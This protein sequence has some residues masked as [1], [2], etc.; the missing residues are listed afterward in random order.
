[1]IGRSA[2]AAASRIVG[3]ARLI[4]SAGARVNDLDACSLNT[5]DVVWLFRGI[6]LWQRAAWGVKWRDIETASYYTGF[7]S[8]ILR[9]YTVRVGHRFTRT[10]EIVVGHLAR[11]NQAAAHINGLHQMM[12]RNEEAGE[13]RRNV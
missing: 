9:S 8:W 11:G 1:M 12:L 6:L 5:R 3:L 7:F 4:K 10:S 13:I 2:R